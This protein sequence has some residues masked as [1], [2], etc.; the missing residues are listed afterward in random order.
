[1]GKFYEAIFSTEIPSYQVTINL[2]HVDSKL[3]R[4]PILVLSLYPMLL[5]LPGIPQC[6][7]P[8]SRA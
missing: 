7:R 2:C 8:L 4:T 3:T 5:L 6:R 1:M